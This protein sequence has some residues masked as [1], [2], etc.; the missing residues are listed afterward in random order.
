M[1]QIDPGPMPTLTASAPA[2]TRACAP[3]AVATLP[4]ITSMSKLALDLGHRLDDVGGMAVGRIDHQH[5]HARPDQRLGA[6]VVVD[7]HRRTDAQPAARVLAGVGEVGELVD[8]L[9]GDQALQFIVFVHQQ[10]FLDFI[11]R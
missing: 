8:V 1:V 2:S 6:L 10:E 5:V 3:S 11:F 9:D 4:A 7:A